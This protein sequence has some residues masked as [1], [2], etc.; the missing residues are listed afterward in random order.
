M[1]IVNGVEYASI[2]IAN[3]HSGENVQKHRLKSK[4]IKFK[5]MYWK[6]KPKISKIDENGKEFI[7]IKN[8]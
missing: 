2:S 1:V 5:N 4:N 7:V 8:E 3:E 6:N